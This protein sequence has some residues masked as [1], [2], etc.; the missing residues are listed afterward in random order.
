MEVKGKQEESLEMNSKVNITEENNTKLPSYIV[1]DLLLDQSNIIINSE[2]DRAEMYDLRQKSISSNSS[3]K[4]INPQ[5]YELKKK[6]AEYS[7]N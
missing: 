3:N 4:S 5:N 7:N 6:I 2:K 1:S